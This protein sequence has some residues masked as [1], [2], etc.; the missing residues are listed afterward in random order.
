MFNIPACRHCEGVLKPAVVFFGEGAF[1][2]DF[3][4]NRRRAPEGG[5]TAMLIV[6]SSLMVYSGFRFR[7][8]GISCG[9]ADRGK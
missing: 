3:V 2:R 5:R 7:T 9:I 1:P 4:D 8:D 6:G